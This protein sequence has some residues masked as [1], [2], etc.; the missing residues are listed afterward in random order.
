MT[1]CVSLDT[2]FFL[3]FM[4]FSESC[5]MLMILVNIIFSKNNFKT[6][7]YGIIYTNNFKTESYGTIYTFKNYF[8]IVFSVFNYKRYPNRS[9]IYLIAYIHLYS[10]DLIPHL[11]FG[12]S[13]HIKIR[14]VFVDYKAI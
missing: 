2:T 1:L 13:L 3:T 8:T 14:L 9:Y 5:V 10:Y 4:F 11:S 6:E 7:S 12:R